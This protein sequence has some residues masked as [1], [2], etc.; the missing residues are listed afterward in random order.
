M[1]AFEFC[2]SGLSSPLFLLPL[3]PLPPFRCS[4][5]SS[6]LLPLSVL[7]IYVFKVTFLS[8]RV[9]HIEK[10]KTNFHEV[11]GGTQ[12]AFHNV[13]LGRPGIHLV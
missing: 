8:M 6:L 7:F 13:T 10:K 11:D 5:L 12:A 3:P 2:V 9:A 1:Q 4:L